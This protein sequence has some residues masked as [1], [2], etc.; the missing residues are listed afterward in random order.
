MKEYSDVIKI[1]VDF[2]VIELG[3]VFIVDVIFWFFI[4]FCFFVIICEFWFYCGFN[5][6]F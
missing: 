1:D 3:E 2:D 6:G 5:G 4:V